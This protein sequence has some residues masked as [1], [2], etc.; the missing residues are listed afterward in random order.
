MLILL[1]ILK[2]KNQ[3][4][5]KF[6]N[7]LVVL[8]VA[9]LISVAAMAQGA[10]ISGNVKNSSTKE[11]AA[12][13]SVTVKGGN[14]GTFTDDKGNFRLSVKS[15]PVTLIISSVGYELQEITVSSGD[16]AI[17]V[18]LR[19][20]NSLG[21]EIVVS[22]TRVAQRILESP[23]SVERVSSAN[24]RNAPAATYY[25]VVGTLKGVD[26]TT[27]S[28]TFKTPSTRGFNGSGS[29]RVNQLVDGM[30]NQAPGLNFSVGSVVGLS[31]LDVDNMELLPG[32]SSALYGP[33][34]MNGTLLINS[35]NPFKYQGLSFQVK[36]GIM[37]FDRRQRAQASPYH[38]WSMRWAKKISEKFAFKIT[39]ELVQA[40]DWAGVDERNYLRAGTAGTIISGDRASDPNY[41]GVNVYG[42]ETTIDLM[43]NVLLPISKQAPFLAPFIY[44]L[45]TNKAINVSRT[46]YTERQIV[47][48]NTVNYKL[49]AS[50][51]YKITPKIEAI[52]SGYWGTG[53]TVYTGSER[54]SL[55]G[56]K[57]GQYK[58]ELLSKNWLLRAY[59]TQENAGESFNATVT[60]RL[61]NEKW[62]S[63]P[64]WYQTYGQTYVAALL[65]GA[66]SYNAHAAARAAADQGRP[67]AGSAQFN[68]LFDEVRKVP[69]SKGGGLFVDK[70]DLYNFEGQYN[71]TEALDNKVEVLI[72]GNYKKYVLNS[73]G[74]LFADSAGTIG[75]SEYGGYLQVAKEFFDRVKVTVSGRYDKNENFKGRFT[76]RATA[77]IKLAK[78]N[79]LRLSYQ[80]AYR[81]P[82]TQQQWINLDIGSNVRL[83]GGNANFRN[84]YNMISNPVYTL[85]SVTAG[86]GVKFNFD[87]YK[88]E[89]V[90]SFEVGYKG[91]V[92]QDKLLIDLYGYTGEYTDFITRRVV[93]QS[94]IGAVP[95][96]LNEARDAN[97]SRMFSLPV[98]ISDKVKTFGYGIG[99][100]YRL[101]KN[102]SL[103]VNLSSDEIDN[104]PAGF[105]ANFNVPKYRLNA[106]LANSGLGKSK[107]YGF[108]VSYRWQDEFYYESD[109]VN[110]MLP[111]VQTL[112]AQVS[113]KLPKTKSILKIGANNLLNQYYYNAAGNSQIGG[114]YYVSFGYNVY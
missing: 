60:T 96:S 5:K 99:L 104:V 114:L 28:L 44:S 108:S 14:T 52:L 7:F 13:V 93:V 102:F 58:L 33:G 3:V 21:Q 48:P 98:N 17:S 4:M 59:T 18:D 31:E 62:K 1:H 32:A 91:L 67:A 85:E 34:G 100:D 40:K 56:L 24:I 80:T 79:N 8:L 30:D 86:A 97:R 41:D 107:R 101:P 77:V 74:T 103:G 25:D 2:Q 19:P 76:P 69:I 72:G 90:V 45:D 49:G 113:Y 88:P 111:A 22:A 35:K 110:S 92:L 23:V 109:F 27:S 37:H 81:F 70:T 38:N 105:A 89:S 68:K 10:T 26:V 75:I 6:T 16:A 53:N 42:D 50:F 12:A 71:L 20:S 55:K 73:E 87:D 64:A 51:N 11:G 46:G 43:R 39:T 63:S 57:M 29:V 47:N 54:Y 83:L 66:V 94:K 36:A 65:S 61:Y 95:S 15:L 112:D 106:T 9:N 82:S 78:N 84:F